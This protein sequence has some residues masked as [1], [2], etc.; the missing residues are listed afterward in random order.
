MQNAKCKQRLRRAGRAYVGTSRSRFGAEITKPLRSGIRTVAVMAF[1]LSQDIRD[2]TFKQAC[3]VA[4]LAMRV[5]GAPGPRRIADKLLRAATS[6]GANLEEAK[7][8]PGRRLRGVC[9]L[10]LAF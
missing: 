9:I 5:S 2:R 4:K 10:H 8:A 1:D 7:A 6:V 3:D